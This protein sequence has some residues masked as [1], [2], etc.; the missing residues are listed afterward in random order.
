MQGV[1][2]KKKVKL[3]TTDNETQKYRYV[4]S[5]NDEYYG[6]KKEMTD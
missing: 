2:V 6:V 3:V 4:F 1:K 5:I